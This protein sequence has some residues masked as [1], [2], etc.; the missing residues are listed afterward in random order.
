M[1]NYKYLVFKPGGAIWKRMC[2]YNLKD[3]FWGHVL[4]KGA[5]KKN[6]SLYW[7]II[8][9]YNKNT[10]EAIISFYHIIHFPP[11]KYFPLNPCVFK[12]FAV[13]PQRPVPSVKTTI[14][15]EQ[16]DVQINTAGSKYLCTEKVWSISFWRLTALEAVHLFSLRS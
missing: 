13:Q 6:R 15:T 9:V 12:G 10:N 2:E 7:K 1:H 4:R 3:L 16:T 8:I 11:P 14:G 5:K